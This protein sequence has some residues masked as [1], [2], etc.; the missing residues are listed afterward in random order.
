MKHGNKLGKSSTQFLAFFYRIETDLWCEML[1]KLMLTSGGQL[2]RDH[3]WVYREKHKSTSKVSPIS[4]CCTQ[5]FTFIYGHAFSPLWTAIPKFH[6]VLAFSA[7]LSNVYQDPIQN[8]PYRTPYLR[9][10]YLTD[11][12]TFDAFY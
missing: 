3:R 12:Q 9:F 8:M 10:L 1:G 7:S 6:Q 5:F 11:K 2:S 4:L